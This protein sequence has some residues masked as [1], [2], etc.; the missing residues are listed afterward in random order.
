V[1]KADYFAVGSRSNAYLS[2]GPYLAGFE[3]YRRPLLL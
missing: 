2:V 1:C 3:E